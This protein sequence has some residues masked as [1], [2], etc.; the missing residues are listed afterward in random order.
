MTAYLNA[1]GLRA[2]ADTIDDLPTEFVCGE[3]DNG[4]GNVAVWRPDGVN[5]PM[6]RVVDSAED[7]ELS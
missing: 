7:E 6:V 4:Y 1:E 3:V 2:L 5:H